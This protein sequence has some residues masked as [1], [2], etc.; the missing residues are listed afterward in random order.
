[1]TGTIARAPDGDLLLSGGIEPGTGGPARVPAYYRLQRHGE[2]G[3]MGSAH[4]YFGGHSV[5]ASIVLGEAT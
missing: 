5:D 3:L 1:V 4:M 2:R